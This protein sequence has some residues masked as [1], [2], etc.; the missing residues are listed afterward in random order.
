MD[1]DDWELTVAVGHM[2]SVTGDLIELS[3]LGSGLKSPVRV[4]SGKNEPT[5]FGEQ[6]QGQQYWNFLL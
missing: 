1:F 6:E 4:N 3:Q 2:E 5:G